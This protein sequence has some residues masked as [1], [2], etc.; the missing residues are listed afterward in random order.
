MGCWNIQE[1]LDFGFRRLLSQSRWILWK[2]ST[3]FHFG[4]K[5]PDLP[6]F[7]G[8][9]SAKP[10]ETPRTRI[11]MDYWVLNGSE[12]SDWIVHESA[13]FGY[14]PFTFTIL[15]Y[16]STGNTQQVKNLENPED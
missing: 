15:K 7:F 6:A 2:F 11:Y 14:N 10:Q 12:P 3:I 5:E 8:S 4:A 13:I 16:C 9:I 1:N